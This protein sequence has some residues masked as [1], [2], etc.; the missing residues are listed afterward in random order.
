MLY[1]C[2]LLDESL[3]SIPVE[4]GES[5]L[6]LVGRLRKVKFDMKSSNVHV[7]EK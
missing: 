1:R 5:I 6:P 7:S 3:I 4:I 2:W